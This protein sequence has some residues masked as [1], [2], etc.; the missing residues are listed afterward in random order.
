MNLLPFVLELLG[1]LVYALSSFF[2]EVLGVMSFPLRNAFILL[3]K[4]GY[5][6]DSFSLNSK[7]SLTFSLFLP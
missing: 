4:S 6:V 7:K 2:L 3:H 5:V 1:V